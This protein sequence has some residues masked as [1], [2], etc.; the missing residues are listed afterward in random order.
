MIQCCIVLLSTTIIPI[1]L[2]MI[3]PLTIII[4]TLTITLRTTRTNKANGFYLTIN[5]LVRTENVQTSNHLFCVHPFFNR[6]TENPFEVVYE[7][8]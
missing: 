7:L 6:A 5:V 1:I 2:I 4:I 3:I 8:V